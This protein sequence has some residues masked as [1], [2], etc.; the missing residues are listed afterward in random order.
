[1]CYSTAASK[2]GNNGGS[3]AWVGLHMFESLY[4]GT[5]M[6]VGGMVPVEDIDDAD[7]ELCSAMSSGVGGSGGRAARQDLAKDLAISLTLSAGWRNQVGRVRFDVV[8]VG[9]FGLGGR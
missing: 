8:E 7:E 5:S 1:M 6:V 3:V 4:G 9:C 2:E